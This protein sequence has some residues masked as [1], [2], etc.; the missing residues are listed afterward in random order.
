MLNNIQ[1]QIAPY[2]SQVRVVAGN[3]IEQDFNDPYA[4]A[5]WLNTYIT[6]SNCA[7]VT[8]V[9][10]CMY[11]FGNLVIS[12]SGNVCATSRANSWNACDVW[13]VSWGATKN[14]SRFPRPLPEIYHG[15]TPS[16]PL[17]GYDALQWK[18]LS[19][20]SIVQKNAGAMYFVGSL[21]QRGNC[22][23]TCNMGNNK[24]EEGFQLL[25]DALYSDTRTRQ[26]LRWSTDIR[27]QP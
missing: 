27:T 18:N 20:Y 7:P 16:Y 9:E 13:Y 25:Y 8:G 1:T 22:G 10:G 15:K 23:D 11:N 12:I 3:D 14:G 19:I 17:Y 2:A 6:A 4:S 26:I 5:Q 24:P 21:T